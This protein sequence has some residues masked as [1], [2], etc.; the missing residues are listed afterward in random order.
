L[1]AARRGLAAAG[2]SKPA[3]PRR[4]LEMSALDGNFLYLDR[5]GQAYDHIVLARRAVPPNA[6]YWPAGDMNPVP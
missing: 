1:A 5:W 4:G 2:R 3:A 6:V